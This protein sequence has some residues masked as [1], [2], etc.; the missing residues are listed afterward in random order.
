MV[1]WGMWDLSMESL[2]QQPEQPEAN[3][4][5]FP[6]R[7]AMGSGAARSVNASRGYAY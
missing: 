5:P 1:V 7:R 3:H 6:R 2:R 4:A